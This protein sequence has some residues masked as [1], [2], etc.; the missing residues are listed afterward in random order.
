MWEELLESGEEGE[1]ADFDV[2][3]EYW[4]RVRGTDNPGVIGSVMATRVLRGKCI[5]LEIQ[6]PHIYRII[7]HVKRA[8]LLDG[9]VEAC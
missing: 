5:K 7:S 3:V 4:K 1:D 6:Y 8:K 9:A 2:E